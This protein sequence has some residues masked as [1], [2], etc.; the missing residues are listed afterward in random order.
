VRD[1][2]VDQ[3][4]SPAGRSSI[5]RLSGRADPW[6]AINLTV[7]YLF[8]FLFQ[9]YDTSVINGDHSKKSCAMFQQE[10]YADDTRSEHGVAA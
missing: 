10:R 2:G 4:R 1:G 8:A 5:T 3:R 7:V 6:H 9:S